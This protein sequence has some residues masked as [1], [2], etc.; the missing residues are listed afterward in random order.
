M[1]DPD[2]P[3]R[4]RRW[5]TRQADRRAELANQSWPTFFRNLAIETAAVVVIVL[6]V[7]AFVWFLSR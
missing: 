5:T 4:F 7:L 2:T 3:G 1:P 6:I